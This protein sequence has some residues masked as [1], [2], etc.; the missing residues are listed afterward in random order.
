MIAIKK[1]FKDEEMHLFVMKSIWNRVEHKVRMEGVELTKEHTTLNTREGYKQV[2]RKQADKVK[3]RTTQAE[4]TLYQYPASLWAVVILQPYSGT[5]GIT[6]VPID[7]IR[8][9]SRTECGCRQ[10]SE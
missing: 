3:S 2:L 6:A 5:A 1:T 4:D 10:L 9:N 7:T 8:L